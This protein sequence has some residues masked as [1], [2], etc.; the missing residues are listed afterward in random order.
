MVL[1]AT[2]G[3]TAQNADPGKERARKPG[4]ADGSRP[5]PDAEGLAQKYWI[6]PSIAAWPA[7]PMRKVHIEYH[8]SKHVPRLADRFNADDF[9]GQ[10]TR[11]HVTGATV[12]AKD[13]DPIPLRDVTVRLNLPLKNAK[14]RG[15]YAAQDI[16]VRR[17]AGG[18]AEVV[19]PRVNI[20][21]VI[22]FENWDG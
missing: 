10:L 1:G 11:A 6:D 22:C 3:L 19:V 18:G 5:L 15:L 20:H 17:A 12:F 16:P 2:P 4:T 14:A 13:M 9:A 8:T 21:E 7:G